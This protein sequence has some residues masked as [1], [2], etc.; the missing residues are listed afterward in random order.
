IPEDIRN[1]IKNNPL[2][3]FLY[4][5]SIGYYPH[6]VHHFRERKEGANQFILIYCV[7]GGGNVEIDANDFRLT[8]NHFIIIPSHT[9]HRYKADEN[10]PWSIYWVHFSGS[11]ASIL[12]D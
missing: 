2:I 5:T 9:P 12:Y 3:N 7:E 6:A 8:P 11:R 4:I 1:N 10:D